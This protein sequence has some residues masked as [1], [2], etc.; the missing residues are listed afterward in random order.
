MSVMDLAAD[1]AS[2]YEETD[3]EKRLALLDE[4]SGQRAAGTD[5]GQGGADLTA[6]QRLFYFRF[7]GDLA[8]DRFLQALLDLMFLTR[9]SRTLKVLERR[10]A[11][12][13][14]AKL[15]LYESDFADIE[16]QALL[17]AE[18]RNAL[19]RYVTTCESDLYGRKFLGMIRSTEVQKAELMR[20]DLEDLSVCLPARLNAAGLAEF[21]EAAE[22]LRSCVLSVSDRL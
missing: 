5:A 12:R 11:R 15:G 22:R 19:Q 21:Q 13:A 18:I 9:S 2:F 10:N 17:N 8:E 20:R 16:I 3:P 14:F 4:I 7:S 6:A 1:L